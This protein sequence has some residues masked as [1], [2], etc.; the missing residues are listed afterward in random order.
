LPLHAFFILSLFALG[1]C[2]GS[3]LNVVIWRLPR[4]QSIV[5]PGSHCPSCGRGIRWFDNIPLLS[6]LLLGGRCR[7]C[8]VRISPR[9]LLVELATALLLVGLY[10][11]YYVAALRAGMGSLPESWP[12]YLSHA[13]LLC[14]LLACSVIDIETFH[15]PLEVCW[16]ATLVG[17][18]VAGTSPRPDLLPAV[19]PV[20]GAACVGGAAGLAVALLLLHRGWIPRSFIDADPQGRDEMDKDLPVGAATETDR[21]RPKGVGIT[22]GQGV[23]PRREVLK[24]LL[25]LLPPI[26]AA[27]IAGL[28][29]SRIPA[30]HRAWLGLY[31][32]GDGWVGRH[33]AGLLAGVFGY[34]V[35]ALWIW[36]IR[37]FG[38]LGFGREAMGLGDLHL[39]AAGGACA[40]WIVPSAA[41]FLA[42]FFGLA[43]AVALLARKGERELPYG[44]W[45]SLGVAAALVLQDK[46]LQLIDHYMHMMQ[47]VPGQ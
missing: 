37:I 10:V 2:V 13:T 39:L 32:L 7:Y 11:A 23:S 15:V 1:A 5:F 21:S 26:L 43:W 34:F 29:V 33:L 44:P 22:A 36:G 35:G 3:F 19:S 24:E 47:Q 27:V 42:P 31:A 30:V 12:I 6:W 28:A 20:T 46:I 45:L 4:G 16:F 40:G 9:Y 41:F 25:F 38:T 18:V 14:A 8:N 17:L